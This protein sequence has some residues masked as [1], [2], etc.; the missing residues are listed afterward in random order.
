MAA[1]VKLTEL[2]AAT[3]AMK[4]SEQPTTIGDPRL[5]EMALELLTIGDPRLVELAVTLLK[6]ALNEKNAS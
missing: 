2:R 3:T 1:A 4:A 6:T 5:I